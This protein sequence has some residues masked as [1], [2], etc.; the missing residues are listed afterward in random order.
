MTGTPLLCTIST[1]AITFRFVSG[2]RQRQL[3]ISG[4]T[5]GAEYYKKGS[6]FDYSKIK[7]YKQEL[8]TLT[9]EADKQTMRDFFDEFEQNRDLRVQFVLT[10][11]DYPVRAIIDVIESNNTQCLIN[12]KAS[13]FLTSR[14]VDIGLDN[15]K[16]STEP[17][18]INNAVSFR[19]HAIVNTNNG[20]FHAE[21]LK[22][23]Y[24]DFNAR[25]GV[26]M[27]FE[28]IVPGFQDIDNAE[29]RY[30]LTAYDQNGEILL[31]TSYRGQLQL[32]CI[33]YF[34]TRVS[35][36][37][38]GCVAMNFYATEQCLSRGIQE[39]DLVFTS[40][41][42]GFLSRVTYFSFHLSFIPSGAIIE[43]CS[44]DTTNVIYGQ[45]SSI[46]TFYQRLKAYSRLIQRGQQLYVAF[47]GEQEFFNWDRCNLDVSD[48]L[49]YPIVGS[50]VLIAILV[51]LMTVWQSRQLI[52]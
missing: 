2:G 47:S 7:F 12:L 44:T 50:C 33:D 27:P 46:I 15:K 43:K 16:Y 18:C 25:G 29:L 30:Y 24:D 32:S 14:Y 34:T 10:T 51:A 19:Q 11:S 1:P 48:A 37:Y 17:T 31:E 3:A 42:D 41:V 45:E 52:Q 6:A 8:S 28:P 40:Q 22:Q 49:L 21:V 36:I 4:S 39:M 20:V 38:G 23:S 35:Q 5:G 26:D 13:G 9:D